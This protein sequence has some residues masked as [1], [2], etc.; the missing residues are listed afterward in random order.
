MVWLVLT[1]VLVGALVYFLNRDADDGQGGEKTLVVYCAAGVKKAVEEAA[2]KFEQET[3]T[4]MSL[5][6]GSSG[7]L[8]NKLKI[9]KEGGLPPGG[10]LYSGGFRLC[11][12]RTRRR[13]HRRVTENRH[14]EGCAWYQAGQRPDPGQLR[15]CAGAKTFVRDMR[16]TYRRWQEDKKDARAIRPLGGGGCGQGG[17]ISDRDGGRIG[18]EG[19]CRYTGGVCMGLGRTA[20]WSEGL[21]NCRSWR[22]A[23]RNFRGGHD[24]DPAFG[25]GAEVCP[26]PLLRRRGRGGFAKHH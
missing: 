12:A 15:R 1:A 2:G 24:N 23:R 22:Q 10:C 20:V 3:G 13:T 19:K 21:L 11:R 4:K 25:P 14:L 6:Y 9:D 8:A 16:S 26:L 18:G 5:E 17:F 7:V